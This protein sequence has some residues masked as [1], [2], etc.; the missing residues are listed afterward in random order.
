LVGAETPNFYVI[1]GQ[2]AKPEIAAPRTLWFTAAAHAIRIELD[3]FAIVYV[4]NH[5]APVVCLTMDM[6][7][8]TV[9]QPGTPWIKIFF[10]PTARVPSGRQ[11]WRSL[12]LHR[13]RRG[14]LD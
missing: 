2:D 3:V 1:F 14:C 8:F 10:V 9:F 13:G 6:E 5:V 7:A 12:F 4:R 11:A